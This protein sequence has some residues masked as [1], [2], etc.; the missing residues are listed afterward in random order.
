V[1]SAELRATVSDG[2]H[3][4]YDTI[5]FQND[6]DANAPTDLQI[7]E[8]V[9]YA[10]PFTQTVAGTVQDAAAVPA[11]TVR[12][13]L[14]PGGTTFDT[15]CTDLTPTDGLWACQVAF[16]DLSS[17][18][19]VNVSVQATDEHGNQSAFTTPVNLLVDLTAPTVNLDAATEAALVDGFITAAESMF[20]GAVNDDQEASSVEICTEIE[21]GLF[22]CE[23][24]EV[25][26]GDAPTGDW[27]L[28][29][30]VADADGLPTTMTFA[31]IDAAGNI[32]LRITRTFQIDSVGPVITATQHITAADAP[33]SGV[34]VLSGSVSDGGGVDSVYVRVKAP[35]GSVTFEQ[36]ALSGGDWTYT[37]TFTAG[38]TYILTV[39]A[40][41]LAG[42]GQAVSHELLVV[43][44][45]QYFIYLPFIVKQS[46]AQAAAE[47]VSLITGLRLFL[48]REFEA[49]LGQLDNLQRSRLVGSGL[50]YGLPL[51][52]PLV[53]LSPAFLVAG[54]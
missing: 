52:F 54:I 8:P 33:L 18:T 39:E 44:P 45:D 30:D 38:G 47:P 17:S 13:E 32:S 11:F 28:D 6:V 35:N 36:L 49:L 10:R 14:L 22:N 26:P 51:L 24:R 15:P 12:V 7:I 29:L 5:W 42:N 48:V 23:I 27:V 34:T 43:G 40:Y 50:D 37:P 21:T 46:A 31:G 53:M 16:G 19:S 1:A 41:D 20:D 2:P 25:M 3:G 4:T 9:T